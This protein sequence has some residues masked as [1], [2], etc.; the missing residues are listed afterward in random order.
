VFIFEPWWNKAAENQGID[1][2]HRMG[3]KHTVNSYSMITRDT[4]EEKIALLQQQKADLVDG[5][6]SADSS[7]T[8]KLSEEDIQ[9]ILG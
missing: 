8:K 5:I 7:F 3:Q 4:I 9:F 6:I 2:L 1:R